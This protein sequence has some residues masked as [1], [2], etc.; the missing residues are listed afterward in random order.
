MQE[1]CQA[2]KERHDGACAAAR[3]AKIPTMRGS[4]GSSRCG[5]W[6]LGSGGGGGGGWRGGGQIRALRY[7]LLSFFYD[8]RP[9]ASRAAVRAVRCCSLPVLQSFD[10]VRCQSCLPVLPVQ[11]F[12][13][14]PLFHVLLSLI[15]SSY[16]CALSQYEYV[17]RENERQGESASRGRRGRQTVSTT[18]ISEIAFPR[19]PCEAAGNPRR[20]RPEPAERGR[21]TIQAHSHHVRRRRQGQ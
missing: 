1:R 20:L 18:T 7:V 2:A 13:L 12:E 11:S 17:D 8:T 15:S 9:A 19:R 16:N 6:G 21:R 5:V 14:V 3:A 4:C 10:A